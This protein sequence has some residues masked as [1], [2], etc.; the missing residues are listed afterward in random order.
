MHIPTVTDQ[1][2]EKVLESAASPV[3]VTFLGSPD[4]SR[5]ALWRWGE[6]RIPSRHIW[7]GVS[8]EDQ[9]TADERIPLLLTTPAA[10]RFVS[11]EPALGPV[12]F[13]PWIGA[14]NDIARATECRGTGAPTGRQGIEGVPLPD[15][16]A[17]AGGAIVAG[18]RRD[19]RAGRPMAGDLDTNRPEQRDSGSG[20]GNHL[21]W[22]I[23]GGESGPHARPFDIAWARS[24]VEQCR[25]GGVACFV[26][27]LGA[28]PQG[29]APPSQYDPVT[30]TTTVQV[31]QVFTI[32]DRK[33]GLMSEWPEDLRVRE[34]PQ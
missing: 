19:S 4:R 31:R 8:V 7:H 15:S 21:D 5:D 20:N 24:A 28:N 29:D 23:V 26:K 1:Q 22:V 25:A 12:D 32:R 16:D 3:V 11:Y 17:R 9:K 27:Q 18:G 2:L 10:V 14:T 13:S 34:F 33:G 30:R 6:G